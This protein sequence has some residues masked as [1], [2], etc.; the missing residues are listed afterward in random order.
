MPKTWKER[1]AWKKEIFLN[2]QCFAA[3]SL[4]HDDTDETPAKRL[5][6]DGPIDISTQLFITMLCMNR[7]FDEKG[8][9]R[10]IVGLL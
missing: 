6:Y 10:L 2:E 3:L 8:I 9:S 7:I 4:L 5:L 1:A